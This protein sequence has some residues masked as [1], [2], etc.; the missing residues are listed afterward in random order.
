MKAYLALCLGEEQLILCLSWE[1]CKK[2][3]ML[4]EE[5]CMCFVDLEKA[6]DSTRES[7][8]MSNDEERNT[9]SFA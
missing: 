1:G 9:R 4:K 8:E 5:S 3:I 2:S 6:F 7:V